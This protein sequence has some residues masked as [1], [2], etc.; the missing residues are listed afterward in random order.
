MEGCTQVWLLSSQ[1]QERHC[2]QLNY[3]FL[4]SAIM[5]TRYSGN[6][7]LQSQVMLVSN[8]RL[9]AQR[10]AEELFARGSSVSSYDESLHR[11]GRSLNRWRYAQVTEDAATTIA[12]LD[13]V[14]ATTKEP[15]VLLLDGPRSVDARVVGGAMIQVV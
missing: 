1:V 10:R 9:N 13:R 4:N 11:A 7:R 14:A 12:G 15:F 5:S 6:R 3:L 2:D 8:A